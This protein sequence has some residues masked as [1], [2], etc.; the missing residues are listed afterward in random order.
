[1]PSGIPQVPVNSPALAPHL[2]VHTL[3]SRPIPKTCHPDR[4]MIV[5]STISAVEGPAF[6]PS[7]P[8]VIPQQPPSLPIRRP[9][10]GQTTVQQRNRSLLSPKDNAGRNDVPNII[11][12][13]ISRK[14]IKI[15]PLVQLT[16][17]AGMNSAHITAIRL[18][19]GR[20]FNLHAHEAPASFDHHVVTRRISPWLGHAQTLLRRLCVSFSISLDQ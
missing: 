3:S 1:M 15:P 20:R 10:A 5:Q 4:S 12:D 8:P 17:R 16:A 14:K 6:P 7:I 13:N 19:V 2:S 18:S 9:L 11:R